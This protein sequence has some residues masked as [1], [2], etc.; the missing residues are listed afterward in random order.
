M[1]KR[2]VVVL[3]VF[4]VNY[5]DA[6]K[7]RIHVHNDYEQSIPFWSAISANADSLEADIFLQ[8]NELYVAHEKSKIKK[9][10]TLDN[11]YLKPLKAAIKSKFV[12]S[13]KP[14]QLLIDIK[15][16]AYSTLN[17]LIK[18]LKNYPAIINN[19]NVNIVISGARPK[20][21]DYSK[22]PFF[23]LFDYQ[24]EDFPQSSSILSKIGL[25]SYSFKDFSVW[26]GKGKMV[27]SEY[28]KL[29]HQIT[30][31]HKLKKTIRF[32]ATPDSKSAWKAL[33]DLKIGFINT[34]YPFECSNYLKTL[35]ERWFKNTVFSKVYKPTYKTD[36]K[37]LPVKNIILMIGDGN[38]LT[39]ISS[40]VLANKGDLTLMQLKS[41]GFMKTQSSDDFT[42]DSAASATAI[43]TGKK[44]YNRAI[45]VDAKGNKV[46]NITE[47]LSKHNYSTACVTTDDIYG[48]TPSAFYAHQKDRGFEN[49]IAKELLTSNLSLFVGGGRK[50][51]SKRDLKQHQFSMV[52][53]IEAIQDSKADKVGYFFSNYFS[54]IGGVPSVLKGRNN[55]LAKITKAS[56]HFL[57]AKNKPFFMMLEAA[58]IDNYGHN[59]NVGGIVTETIDFDRAITEAIKFA[60]KD[61]QTL[62]IVLADHETSGFSIPQGNVKTSHIEGAFFSHDHT[63]VMVPVF[64]YGPKSYE[65]EGCYE[66][67]DVYSKILNVLSINKNKSIVNE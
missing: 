50:K 60:D 36:N 25:V 37:D 65:F 57:N 56:L 27:A 17:V 43:A 44:T 62:V 29:Q 5:V 6:Q 13:K 1:Y 16:D 12:A 32:W 48:A 64:A 31:V 23:I 30:K 24:E 14:I 7:P 45:G 46:E 53:T 4:V 67:S 35:P 33:S 39:Q 41:S 19:N 2:L 20:A 8:N 66:N 51:Y 38:G 15:T 40:A 52:K 10:K 21:K 61:K 55:D 9:E 26:N 63:G 58:K 22:Y 59:N 54:Y 47:Y 34:D 42:T 18:K 11:L 3:I 28:E 49:E